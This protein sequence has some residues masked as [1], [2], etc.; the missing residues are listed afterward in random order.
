MNEEEL[1]KVWVALDTRITSIN[2]RTKRQ[3]IQITE[4]AKE[5]VSLGERMTALECNK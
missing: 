2:D 3:T 1:S 4:L 5:M